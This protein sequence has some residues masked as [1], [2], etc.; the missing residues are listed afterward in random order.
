MRWALLLLALLEW[1]DAR[2][3]RAYLSWSIPEMHSFL[4]FLYYSKV[5]VCE[6]LTLA[7][8][9]VTGVRYASLTVV[10]N[11]LTRASPTR[12]HDR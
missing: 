10:R 1:V 9:G 12:E 3:G 5:L 7:S 8:C 6:T 11:A 4:L 2:T